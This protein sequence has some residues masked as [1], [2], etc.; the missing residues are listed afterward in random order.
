MTASVFFLRQNFKQQNIA[1]PPAGQ[2]IDDGSKAGKLEYGF[3]GKFL[4]ND[5]GF[6]DRSGLEVG[7]IETVALIDWGSRRVGENG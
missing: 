6:E 1:F 4:L 3:S 7:Q 2:M 5:M